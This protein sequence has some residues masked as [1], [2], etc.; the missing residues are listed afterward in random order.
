L[1]LVEGT[2][3]PLFLFADCFCPLWGNASCWKKPRL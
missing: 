1:V 3:S 2:F